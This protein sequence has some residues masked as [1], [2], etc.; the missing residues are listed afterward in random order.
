MQNDRTAVDGPPDLSKFLILNFALIDLCPSVLAEAQAMEDM[1]RRDPVKR[2]IWISG[3]LLALL[4]VWASALQLR[5]ILAKSDLNRVEGKMASIATGY[6]QVM[7]NQ[8]RIAET[9]AKL[10]ALQVLATNRFLHG[11]LLDALQRTTIDEVQLVHLKVDQTYFLVEEIKGRTNGSKVL[12]GTPATLTEKITLSLDGTDSSASPGDQ[13]P[14]FKDA[15]AANAYFCGQVS[16]TNQISLKNLSAP[17]I[18]PDTGRAMVF[19]TLEF[20]YPEK[21]R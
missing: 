16:T 11:N 4:L 9:D 8:K 20:R 18:S 2:V 10:F 15:L 5:A 6:K 19:F 12:P 1:R 17:Q 14:K 13:V 7:E 21:T 3:L